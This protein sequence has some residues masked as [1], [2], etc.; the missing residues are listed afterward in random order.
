MDDKLLNLCAVMIM[1]KYFSCDLANVWRTCDE[2]SLFVTY[3][4]PDIDN[5]Q[6]CVA[7]HNI[8]YTF[9]FICS[10][11]QTWY[12]VPNADAFWKEAK[13]FQNISHSCS[14]FYFLRRVFWFILSTSQLLFDWAVAIRKLKWKEENYGDV[15]K[16]AFF[17]IYEFFDT[18]KL[19]N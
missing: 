7:L 19:K 15:T 14:S 10:Q 4:T 17:V 2:C 11:V 12:L 8:E 9:K 1:K 3:E 6:C 5:N 18:R 16:A 13:A